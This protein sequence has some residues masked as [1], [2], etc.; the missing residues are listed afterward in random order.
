MSVGEVWAID[1]HAHLGVYAHG[2]DMQRRFMSGDAAQ[3]LR[4][5]AL[6]RTE[7]TIVSSLEA[8]LP[9]G[10]GDAIAGNDL[11]LRSVEGNDGLRLWAVLD[12]RRSE[13][14]DQVKRLLAHPRCM[15]I[16]IHPEQHQYAIA[17]Y[18]RKVFE[19]A[20]RHGAVVQTHSGQLRCM[21]M[22]FV[23]LA[24][25]FSEVAL[26]LSHLGFCWNEDCT[27]QVRA[28]Q[29]GRHDNIYTDTSSAKSITPN[30]LEW[31]VSEVGAHRILYGTD[32]PLYF[33][34]MQR[35]RVDCADLSDHQ[36]RQILH[37]N[38]ERLLD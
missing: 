5:A 31:A 9:E 18:G 32:S 33:A 19:F 1:V 3:V 27:Q 14:F 2:D 21:P 34:P 4:L 11:A 35:S 22:D 10:A 15:G 38:A 26:I 36:K 28:I 37:E 25:A 8:L 30:L 6:A 12:P 13:S 23:P 24:D 7:R 29:A 16:K 17:D 20:A